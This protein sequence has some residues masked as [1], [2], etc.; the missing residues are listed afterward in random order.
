MFKET[1]I[2]VVNLNKK[3]AVVSLKYVWSS[4]P[5]TIMWYAEI[6]V[7]NLIIC[8]NYKLLNHKYIIKKPLKCKTR[9]I[10]RNEHVVVIK[11]HQTL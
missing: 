8:K 11:L 7:I 10:G 2:L 4:Q 1:Y 3:K 5:D 9:V 6:K